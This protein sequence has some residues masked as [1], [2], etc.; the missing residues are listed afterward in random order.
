MLST[1][2][3]FLSL[4]LYHPLQYISINTNPFVTE[5]SDP[6]SPYYNN[7]IAITSTP[8]SISAQL[9]YIESKLSEKPQ[10][11]WLAI[12]GHHSLVGAAK[13]REYYQLE[14]VEMER[15]GERGRGGAGRGEQ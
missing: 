11:D 4:P 8:A 14:R 12:I 9:D 7:E 15:E 10:P 2:T 3:L 1:L 5:Y 6:K 13:H